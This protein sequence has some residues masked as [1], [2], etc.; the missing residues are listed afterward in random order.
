MHISFLNSLRFKVGFGYF[1]LL[2]INI[3]VT[4]WG[5]YNFGRLTLAFT[6]ILD[7]SY[8]HVVVLERMAHIVDQ[9]EHGLTMILNGEVEEGNSIMQKM[10]FIKSSIKQTNGE[11]YPMPARSSIISDQRTRDIKLFLIHYSHLHFGK[12]SLPHG[13]IMEI[14]CVLFLNVYRITHSG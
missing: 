10:N 12:N 6:S 8:P 5:I 13:H 14:L 2:F 3:S 9:H 7:E 4:A 11:T 1:V